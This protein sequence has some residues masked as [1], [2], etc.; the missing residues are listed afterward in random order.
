MSQH[1]EFTLPYWNYASDN[2]VSLQLPDR[3]QAVSPDPNNPNVLFFDD[4]GLGFADGQATGAQNVAM[5]NGG[6]MP[7]PLTQYGPA[8]AAMNMFPSDDATTQF[9]GD[10]TAPAYLNL[11]FTGRLE[12]VPHDFVH[13][14]V[15]GWMQNVPSA[16]GDPIF[17]MH[18]CQI[19]R[20][21]AAW[22]AKP[23]ASY[24]WGTTASDPDENT[25]KKT[26]MG[27]FVDENGQLVKVTLGDAINISALQ[28]AYDNLPSP[29]P[30]AVAALFEAG[31]I[32]GLPVAL[33]SMSAKGL[34]VLSGGA[35][36]TLAPEASTEGLKAQASPSSS[37][38][39]VLTGIKLLRRPPAPLSVFIN[40][41]KQASPRLNSP[42]YVGTLNLFN[43]DLGTGDLMSHGGDD[44]PPGSMLGATAKFDVTEI[45]R[46]QLAKGLWDGGPIT[47][48]ISTIG[49][50][51]AGTTTYLT[52][53]S[54]ALTP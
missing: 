48:T 17:F 30:Q 46:Q 7:F 29:P 21:Y 5:N 18:H 23:D 1:P 38:T 24:N 28:Y 47:V 34:S 11:G 52:I 54:I 6:Y 53:D 37:K 8:L 36:V 41:P 16:A 4:R 39:L 43:F 51:T 27:A 13:T 35:T 22:E 15:G 33:A 10:L 19:D 49:A 45:L 44:M 32:R 3:F 26:K 50:D 25:W 2:G 12:L 9:T 31:P 20:L 42:Y 14:S 40:L